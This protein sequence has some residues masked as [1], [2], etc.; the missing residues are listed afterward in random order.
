MATDPIRAL[1][2]EIEAAEGKAERE[3]ATLAIVYPHWSTAAVYAVLGSVPALRKAVEAVLARHAGAHLCVSW[4]GV[5]PRV[6]GDAPD[7]P[8]C[9]TVLDI[10]AALAPLLAETTREG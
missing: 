8:L 9:P 5:A 10:Q 1:L 6:Y 2:A 4:P 3:C 7:Y